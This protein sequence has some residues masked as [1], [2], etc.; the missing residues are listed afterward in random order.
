MMSAMGAIVTLDLPEDSP[1]FD[2]PW[3]I[4]F[5]PASDD[6]DEVW[7]PIVCGPYSRSH[8]FAVANAV[9]IEE[10]LLAVVEPLQ[11]HVEVEAIKAEITRSR[12]AAAEF[13]DEDEDLPDD[14]D[15]HEHAGHDH[16]GHMY[17]E[18]SAVPT[19][20]ELRAGFAKIAEKLSA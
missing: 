4:T 12:E 8:A 18:P 10:D 13:F 19:P 2:L 1:A 15:D 14:G 3:I 16:E 20:S 17:P 5:G 11:P 9:V 6:A 7:E